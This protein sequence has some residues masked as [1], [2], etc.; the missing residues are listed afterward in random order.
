MNRARILMSLCM[1]AVLVS[2]T[3]LTGCA[4]TSP[5]PGTTTLASTVV[6]ATTTT[7]PRP[8]TTA[9]ATTSSPAP[10]APT[11]LSW[12]V[13]DVGTSSYVMSGSVAESLQ[14]KT[15]VRVRMTPISSD[16]GKLTVVRS[17]QTQ[18]ATLAGS[19]ILAREGRDDFAN[20]TWG[21]QRLRMMYNFPGAGTT[22]FVTRRNSDIQTLKDLKGKK[23]PFVIGLP[24][25]NTVIE[26]ALVGFS[27]LTWTDVVKV[28]LPSYAASIDAL[29]QGKTDVAIANPAASSA[30]Q[31]E[32]GQGGIRWIPMPMSDKEGWR[33]LNDYAPGRIPNT[34]TVGPGISA[35]APAEVF[36]TPY[37]FDTYESLNSDIAYFTTKAFVESFSLY[38]D[39][40]IYL[41]DATVDKVLDIVGKLAH[42]WHPG[43]IRYLKEIGKWTPALEGW[44]NK[45]LQREESLSKAWEAM[46]AEAEQTKL[47]EDK[48][49]ALWTKYRKDVAPVQ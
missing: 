20:R 25:H 48:L 11:V 23:V 21:P 5:T 3:V 10:A 17:G 37:S 7:A 45:V 43:S 31:I 36:D 9:G 32:S 26:G 4:K 49:P 38:K 35:S 33:I 39:K 47:T 28:E 27:K 18:L 44:N 42:A 19:A 24:A 34:V 41:K 29:I 12:A 15:S 8:G 14:D 40:Q 13:H 2:V 22:G 6:P 16:V 1:I 30:V 46:L